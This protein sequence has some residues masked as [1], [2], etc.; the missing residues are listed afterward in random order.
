MQP[1]F[2][3]SATYQMLDHARPTFRYVPVTK[4]LACH[5]ALCDHLGVVDPTVPECSGAMLLVQY[6]CDHAGCKPHARTT[7]N[8]QVEHT[9]MSRLVDPWGLLHPRY[10]QLRLFLGKQALEGLAHPRPGTAQPKD[11]RL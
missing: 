10:C 4:P 8:I 9:S 3:V 11:P 1:H 2:L 6:N 5:F 7:R